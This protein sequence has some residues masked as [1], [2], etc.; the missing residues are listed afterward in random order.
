LDADSGEIIAHVMTDQDTGDASQVEPLL[1]QIDAPIDQFTADRA[2]DGRPTYNAV[3]RHRADA[4]VVV[5]PRANAVDRSGKRIASQRDRHIAAIKAEG[6]MKWQAASRYGK[7]SLIE[8]TI[9]RYKS[10]IGHRLRTR[11]FGAQ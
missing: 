5:P 10:I 2:Y 8:T 7:R 4:A 3:S 1:D 6:R 9:G 11:S